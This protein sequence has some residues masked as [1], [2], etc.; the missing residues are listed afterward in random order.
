[1]GVRCA[2]KLP[3]KPHL[4]ILTDNYRVSQNHLFSLGCFL[5]KNLELFGTYHNIYKEYEENQI[6]ERVCSDDIPDP[7]A[8]HYL[9]HQAVVRQEK[10]TTKV[11]QVFEASA[12]VS[13]PS[14][15]DCLYAGPNHV[16]YLRKIFMV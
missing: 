1:M 16:N 11:R 9:P 10:E 12:K 8:V 15:N 4:D 13:G 5:D 14:P 6:I 7:G 2:T 3:I